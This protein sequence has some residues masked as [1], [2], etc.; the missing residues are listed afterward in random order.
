M[1]KFVAR[2][3][4]R[5]GAAVAA[6][7]LA[8]FAAVGLTTPPAHAAGGTSPFPAALSGQGL[9]TSFSPSTMVSAPW[10]PSNAPGGCPGT[11]GNVGTINSSGYAQLAT[12]GAANDCEAIQSP[13]TSGGAPQLSTAP[14]TTYEALL[15][16]SSFNDWPA[17]WMYGNSWPANGE[18]D[19]VEGGFGAST[20]TWH[21]A[22][23]CSGSS[24]SYTIGPDAWDCSVVPLASGHPA[25]IA[26]G[27]W[28]TVDISF[29]TSGV[30]VYYNGSL[31][32]SIPESV[33]EAGT[34][35]MFLAITEGSCDQ[36]G[37]N[38]CSNA[39]G[40]NA[41][42]GTTQVQY[43]NEYSTSAGGGGGGTSAPAVVTGAVSALTSTT[44]TLN[45]TVN[46]DGLATTYT[47]DGGIDT[48]YGY[49][50]PSPQA[51]VGSGTSPVAEST[52][53]TGLSPST[54]YDIRIEATNA[55]GTT[56]GS[57]V[58]FTTPASGGGTSAPAV[59][60]SAATAVTSTTA[61]LNGTVNPDGLATTYTFD[62]GTDTSYGNQQPSPQAS[63]GSGTSPVAESTNLTGL[64]PSTTYHV[65]IE[66][67]NADGTTDGSDV[68]FTTS[69]SGGG[70][71]TSAPTGTPS[72]SAVTSG[73]N[74]LTVSW[75]AISGATSYEV[76]VTGPT[77][78]L[79]ADSHVSVTHAAYSIATVGTNGHVKV[80]AEN[81]C[82]EGPW[83]TSHSWSF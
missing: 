32:E 54:N 55:D 50:Q 30:D 31:Y 78:G 15:N 46:P 60:S 20:V 21:G 36:A 10:N 71:C 63:V 83:S 23:S 4:S 35:P 75:G 17:F 28:T 49:Q 19:A 24:S 6:V 68:T 59:V 3:R 33:T 74:T 25:D 64:S 5:G 72:V 66:A 73:G 43:V 22:G 9:V 76:D 44:V 27:S 14:G 16:F 1:N 65:R 26:A 69:A 2:M 29:T 56:Y 37:Y 79:K 12:T 80:R 13:A 51:S 18:I 11:S 70:G 52:N 57:D 42:A 48:A 39:P 77:G 47:F 41:P 81:S 45:G 34:D 58:A 82:G 61:T 67:T 62:G 38:A 40:N 8:S 53:L 7:L